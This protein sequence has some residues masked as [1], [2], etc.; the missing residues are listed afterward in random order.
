MLIVSSFSSSTFPFFLA[1]LPLSVHH[2]TFS[3]Q[4]ANL[5]KRSIFFSQ[6][7]FSVSSFSILRE[8]GQVGQCLRRVDRRMRYPT[9]KPTDKASN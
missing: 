3:K 9:N 4:N 8:Q 5:A 7:P 1:A 6:N 2:L